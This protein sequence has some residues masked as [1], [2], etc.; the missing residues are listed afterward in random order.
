M[1]ELHLYEKY[2][3]GIRN[4]SNTK[5]E[6]YSSVCTAVRRLATSSTVMCKSYAIVQYYLV[7]NLGPLQ[8][9]CHTSVAEACITA[10]VEDCEEN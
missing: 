1:F 4:I 2:R 9:G 3:P 5:L 10:H 7:T 8:S 6:F